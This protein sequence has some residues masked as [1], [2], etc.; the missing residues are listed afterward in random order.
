M[1]LS[2]LITFV[3]SLAAIVLFHVPTLCAGVTE[4]KRLR[5]AVETAAQE[6]ANALKK[7]YLQAQTPEGARMREMAT[8]ALEYLKAAPGNDLLEYY[9]KTKEK[10]ERET[11]EKAFQTAVEALVKEYLKD[12]DKTKEQA[13]RAV[14]ATAWNELAKAL[15]KEAAGMT[16]GTTAALKL[17]KDATDA[18][19]LTA[20]L[21][22]GGK[23]ETPEAA[24]M[25]TGKAVQQ[26]ANEAQI[27]EA[28]ISSTVDAV[29]A[30]KKD[31]HH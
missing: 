2:L 8:A 11:K 15:K 24:G 7:D 26:E 28:Q 1:Q 10:K 31:G 18:E 12:T 23:A 3:L 9:V 27:S 16:Q 29:M 19:K 17:Q 4:M 21:E 20:E 6:V 13:L 25:D 14:Q 30:L 5:G 22:A